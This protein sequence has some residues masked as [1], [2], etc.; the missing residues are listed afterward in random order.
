[1]SEQ[2]AFIFPGQ[3]SQSQGML[4][5]FYEHYPIVGETFEQASDVLGYNLWEVVQHDPERLSQTA[6]TQPALLTAS[7]AILRVINQHQTVAP[8]FV[9]GHSLGEYSALVAANAMTFETAVKLVSIRGEAMQNAVPVGVGAVSAILGLNDEVIAEVCEQAAEGETVRAVNF[10]AP[11]Q[12]V[13]AGHKAAVERANEL[14]KQ[15]G[16]KKTQL[17]PVSVPV[18]CE[19]M[20]PAA[21]KLEQAL[22]PVAIGAPRFPVIHNEDVSTHDNADAIRTALVRQVYSPVRWAETIRHMVAGGVNQFVE[23]GAGKVLTG[24]NK[25]IDKSTVSYNTATV[26]GLESVLQA[27]DQ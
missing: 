8:A 21:D 3:G 2:I 9:A 18:H 6:T 20:R 4:A 1:M 24:L 25:R 19:L 22:A 26:A 15:K 13:I 17:L 11:G 14:A 23:V 10:N 12:V 16:A 7:I 5:D 27:M